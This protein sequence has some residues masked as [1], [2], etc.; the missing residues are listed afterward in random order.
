METVES[1]FKSILLEVEN[2]MSDAYRS[3]RPLDPE[4]PLSQS[5]LEYGGDVVRDYIDH[6]ES[7]L[8]FEHLIYMVKE[9][10]LVISELCQ[11][12]IECLSEILGC[13]AKY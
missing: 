1:L 4:H 2:L 8:A 7:V 5:G 9:P 13:N 11:A 12:R 6:S 3:S 10:P